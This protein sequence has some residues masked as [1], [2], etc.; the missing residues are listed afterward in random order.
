MRKRVF[1]MAATAAF[2]G[3]SIPM[4]IAGIGFPD[5]DPGDLYYDDIT[6]IA[7]AGI[8]QGYADGTFRPDDSVTRGEMS[9][10]SHRGGGNVA[11][12]QD[13]TWNLIGDE[14]G[15]ADIASV[16]I[17][18]NGS[19]G[20]QYVHL[21][22]TFDA[23]INETL[24]THSTDPFGYPRIEVA[25]WIRDGEGFVSQPQFVLIN[26]D[27]GGGAVTV[28]AVV[29]ASPGSHTYYLTVTTFGADIAGI[30]VAYQ[31]LTATT[32]PF[33]S[34]ITSPPPTSPAVGSASVSN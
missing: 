14:D 8:A 27:Y 22:G 11:H 4:A 12:T 29:L 10:F 24:A 30:N 23:W 26:T 28:D 3:A 25:G 1:I 19:G 13:G 5:V 31:S 21:I 15:P 17:D 32:F 18:V 2:V 33:T 6:A 9:A 20:A 34:G 16:T 7:G